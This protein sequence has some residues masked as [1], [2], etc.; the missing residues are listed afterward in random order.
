MQVL[1]PTIL[2][3]PTSPVISRYSAPQVK[4]MG[5]SGGGDFFDPVI[6]R[7][8]KRDCPLLQSIQVHVIGADTIAYDDLAVIQPGEGL[9]GN[10][11]MVNQQ[12]IKF[13]QGLF[14]EVVF[15]TRI[16]IYEFHI[17]AQGF[18]LYIKGGTIVICDA[19]NHLLL[20]PNSS[21]AA[22]A[23]CSAVK[24]KCW[25]NSLCLPVPP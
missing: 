3:G 21:R 7:I 16:E 6:G 19:D 14:I 23:I 22:S 4:H 24:P 12:G 5:G 15:V 18:R 25:I 17:A 20:P 13:F 8:A 1:G 10:S 2:K 11:G 9:V